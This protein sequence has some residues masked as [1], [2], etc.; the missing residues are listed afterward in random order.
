MKTLHLSIIV[1]LMILVSSQA[2]SNLVFAQIG[3]PF[4]MRIEPPLTQFKSG[5]KASYVMCQS[6]YFTLVIKSEDNSPACVKLE[7]A[8]KLV[9]RGWGTW[10]GT[11]MQQNIPILSNSIKIENSNFT[12]N[13]DISGNGT[14]LGANMDQ[15]SKSL[16]LSLETIGN[17]T[18]TVSIPRALLDIKKNERGIGGFYMIEDGKETSFTQIRA[19]TTDRT[20]SIPF[21]NGTQKIQIIAT[22]LI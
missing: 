9:E 8:Q 21:V 3:K 4:D 16:I 6:N 15:P 22:Q 13:Y 10:I 19:V 14:V 2:I 12:I 17:G 18:L 5:V 7:T 1:L 11:S 20:F